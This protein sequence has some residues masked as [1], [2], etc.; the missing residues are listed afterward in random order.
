M[1]A[2]PPRLGPAPRQ[3]ARRGA[4]LPRFA[5]VLAAAACGLMAPAAAGPAAFALPIPA[6]RDGGTAPVA[7]VPATTVRVVT[8]G[9]MAGWPVTLIA[10]GA[11]LAA[12]VAAVL[13][14]RARA[15]R[16]TV[17]SPTA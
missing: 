2:Y 14:G 6:G 13:L 8:A 12:A 16:R 11:A 17:P 4:R 3:R 7:P 9:G 1:F 10:V 15:T 5:A